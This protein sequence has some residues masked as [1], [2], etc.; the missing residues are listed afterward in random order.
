M[1][2]S[3]KG[4]LLFS[5]LFLTMIAGVLTAPYPRAAPYMIVLSGTVVILSLVT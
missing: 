2:S 5:L 1:M 3:P 4:E